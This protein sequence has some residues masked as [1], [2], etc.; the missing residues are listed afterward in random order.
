MLKITNKTI[1]FF[2]EEFNVDVSNVMMLFKDLGK[3]LGEYDY[4]VKNTIFINRIKL[5][6][7]PKE[8]GYM[9]IAHELMHLCQYEYRKT[10]CLDF[11]EGKTPDDYDYW[12]EEWCDLPLEIDA[13]FMELYYLHCIGISKDKLIKIGEYRF[14]HTNIEILNA[15]ISQLKAKPELVEAIKDMAKELSKK[16]DYNKAV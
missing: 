6:E 2:K 3:D 13:R 8:F 9:T 4:A 10:L 14:N 1:K 5:E 16:D 11:T 7:Y 12:D 15:H